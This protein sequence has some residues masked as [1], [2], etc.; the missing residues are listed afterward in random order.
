MVC[1]INFDPSSCCGD[2]DVFDG[3]ICDLHPSPLRINQYTFLFFFFFFSRGQGCHS[4][5]VPDCF[6]I[7]PMK[8]G[9]MGTDR[10]DFFVVKKFAKLHGAIP[11]TRFREKM[12]N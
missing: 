11:Y 2:V 6:L 12:H 4:L 8:G 3:G 10:S 5:T 7:I 9:K 1:V